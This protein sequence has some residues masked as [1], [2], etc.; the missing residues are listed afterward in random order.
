[1]G[2]RWDFRQHGYGSAHMEASDDNGNA[3]FPKWAG[4]VNRPG[5]LVGLNS[6]KG[7]YSPISILPD[8]PDYRLNRDYG[9][10]LVVEV[11][12]NVDI[13]AQDSSLSTIKSEAVET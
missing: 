7:N 13:F 1:M 9:A 12:Y 5:K 8:S 10:V 11:S 3:S 2:I 6:Y 4:D